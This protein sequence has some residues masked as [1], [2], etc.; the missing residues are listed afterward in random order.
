MNF[1]TLLLTN[2]GTTNS[3]ITDTTDPYGLIITVGGVS[4]VGGDFSHTAGGQR[5]D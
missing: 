2:I 5:Y 4:V 1:G 3:V